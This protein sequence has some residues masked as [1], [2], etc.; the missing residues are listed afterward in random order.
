[1]EGQSK[2]LPGIAEKVLKSIK[3][4]VEEQGVKLPITE[5]EGEGKHK[6]IASGSKLEEKFQECSKSDGVGLA[7]NVETVG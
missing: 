6:V 1:M 5:G 7:T 3:R 2:E 4:E